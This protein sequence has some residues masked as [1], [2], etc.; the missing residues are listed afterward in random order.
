MKQKN[1]MWK[2]NRVALALALGTM[3]VT[4]LS[5]TAQNQDADEG[6]TPEITLDV[7]VK[8]EQGKPLAGVEVRAYF[9][10]PFASGPDKAETDNDG[11]VTLRG[12][13]TLR[14]SVSSG[15]K[16]SKWYR[17][18]SAIIPG[19]IDPDKD[20]WEI[21]GEGTLVL[22]E[23]K[24]QV[25]LVARKVGVLFPAED[26][27]IGFDVE[28]GEFVIPHGRGI[29]SD[30]LFKVNCDG[31]TELDERWKTIRYTTLD[32]KLWIKFPQEGEGWHAVAKASLADYSILK[33]P[34][35]APVDGYLAERFIFKNKLGETATPSKQGVFM[36]I[37]RSELP[38]GAVQYHYLKLNQD[39]EFHP[40]ESGTHTSDLG[41]AKTYGG[42]KFTYFYNPTPNDRNL[43]FDPDEN[44]AKDGPRV[45]MEQFG[46]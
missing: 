20:G 45:W 12:K 40:F 23:K 24:N 26:V 28:V 35:K 34:Y 16:D 13:A 19:G 33:M 42:I 7:V 2:L 29:R 15:G 10:G 21:R 14:A 43:E 9:S 1:N 11:R 3:V 30:I 8:N 18:S 44:L 17:S 27:W 25:P 41:K 37:R 6:R 39:I 4:V 22:R 38:D 36:R 5:L 32:S 46:L 31:D